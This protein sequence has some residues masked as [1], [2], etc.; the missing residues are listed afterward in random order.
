MNLQLYNRK[1]NYIQLDVPFSIHGLNFV[2]GI[3]LFIQ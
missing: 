2:N 1:A 3:G